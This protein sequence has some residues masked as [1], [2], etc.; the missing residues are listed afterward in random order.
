MPRRDYCSRCTKRLP[1]GSSR[2]VGCGGRPSPNVGRSGQA[3]TAVVVVLLGLLTV[4]AVGFSDRYVP[5]V[6]DWYSR[7]VIHYLPEPALRFAPAPDEARAFYICAKS[8]VRAVEEEASVVTFAPESA[9]LAAEVGEGRYR[10][11]SFVEEA[12]VDGSTLQRSFTCRLRLEGDS[13]HIEELELEPPPTS[14]AGT[15]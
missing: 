1:A 15:P 3:R 9:V 12:R 2:C 13:W 11:D 4:L 10:L 14:I 8:V 6:A 5:A 7:M